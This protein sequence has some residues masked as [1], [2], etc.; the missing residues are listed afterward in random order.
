MS[1]EANAA[2]QDG[3]AKETTAPAALVPSAQ[4]P[5][6][7]PAMSAP[8]PAVARKPIEEWQRQKVIVPWLFAF[9]S[10]Q[11][12]WPVGRELTEAEFDAAIKAAF[13]VAFR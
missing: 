6:A 7:T 11:H 3:A 12:H 1:N 5:A 4:A 2:P 9:A 13:D 10:T 8:A